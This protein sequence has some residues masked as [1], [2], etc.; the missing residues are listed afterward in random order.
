[1]ETRRY[2]EGGG[3]LA[4]ILSQLAS[5]LSEEDRC[6]FSFAAGKITDDHGD[7]GAAFR[8]Y[9]EGNRLRAIEWNSGADVALGDSV[10][11]HYDAAEI[12]RGS[13]L[14]LADVSPIFIVGMPRSGT[15]LV[16]QILA[17]HPQV[18]GAGEL[19]DIS[20]IADDMQ[21]RVQPAM[22]Y[23]GFLAHLPAEAFQGYARAY[24]DRVAGL[25]GSA[26]LRGVDKQPFNF[27]HLGFIRQLFPRARIIH[28]VRDPLDVGLSCYFQNFATGV[29]FSFDLENIGSYYTIYRRIMDHWDQ[30][31]PG[32]IHELSYADLVA[33]PEP[34]VRALLE[35]CELPWDDHCLDF[36]GTERRVATASAWQ[37]RQSLY[38]R[39]VGRHRHYE[40]Y[41]GPLRA[42]LS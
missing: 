11:R 10:L 9:R 38:Q 20:A 18:F 3:H 35:Y 42:Q 19:K 12:Q 6:Y 34:A 36:A 16:E 28:T 40:K 13:E 8:H 26:D 7:Y 29:E 37:V 2:S 15:S 25:A 14:G 17:S 31:M 41:L 21:K 39:S 24:L 33:D 30:V 22:N 23:P 32:A 5:D 1:M 27:Y 4:H